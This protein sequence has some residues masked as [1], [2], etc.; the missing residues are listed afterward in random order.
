MPPAALEKISIAFFAVLRDP[1]FP[2]NQLSI[3]N[4][5]PLLQCSLH[6]GANSCSWQ[7]CLQLCLTAQTQEC[8]SRTHWVCWWWNRAGSI[9]PLMHFMKRKWL[10]LILESYIYRMVPTYKKKELSF[11]LLNICSYIEFFKGGQDRWPDQLPWVFNGHHR[12]WGWRMHRGLLQWPTVKHTVHFS[13]TL[14]YAFI[15][16]SSFTCYYFNWRHSSSELRLLQINQSSLACQN[17]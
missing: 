7:H 11:S 9:C 6:G 4:S 3:A 10:F 16:N 2:E 15:L 12:C 1:S 17:I 13:L 14:S 5:P 8:V